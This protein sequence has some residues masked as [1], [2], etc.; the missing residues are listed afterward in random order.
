MKL[1]EVAVGEEDSLVL[2]EDSVCFINVEEG[3]VFCWDYRRFAKSTGPLD[4]EGFNEGFDVR[5]SESVF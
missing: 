1:E 3:Q 2:P 5:T 4:V